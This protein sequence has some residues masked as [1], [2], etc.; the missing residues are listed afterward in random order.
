MPLIISYNL[1]S[2]ATP[3]YPSCL[4]KK[5]IR[6]VTFTHNLQRVSFHSVIDFLSYNCTTKL[7]PPLKLREGS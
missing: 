7:V 1:Y 2:I 4:Y 3:E 5:H 6:A